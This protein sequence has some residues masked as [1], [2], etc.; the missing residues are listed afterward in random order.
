MPRRLLGGPNCIW[1]YHYRRREG[2][3]TMLTEMGTHGGETT[4]DVALRGTLTSAREKPQEKSELTFNLR[5][6]APN[7]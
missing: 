2:E 6:L 1:W 7:V 4:E 5:C 3:P